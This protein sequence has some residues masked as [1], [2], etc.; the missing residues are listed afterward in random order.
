[1]RCTPGI[2]IKTK[3]ETYATFSVFAD[4]ITAFPSGNSREE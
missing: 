1:M 4:L 3:E 2:D